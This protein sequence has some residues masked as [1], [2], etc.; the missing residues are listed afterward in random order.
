MSAA[1]RPARPYE[2]ALLTALCRRS[3]AHWGND[4]AFMAACAAELTVTAERIAAGMTFVREADGAVAGMYS[5]DP[6][7]DPARIELDLLYVDPDAIGSGHGRALMEH[8]KAEARRQGARLLVVQADPNAAGFYA[9]MGGV[10]VGDR[11]SDSV[12]GR[13][14]PVF[15]IGLPD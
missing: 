14:L 1:I 3:K 5:L 7:D 4:A 6:M 11:P 2:A 10:Q 15:E 12:E 9:A 8:A 13:S